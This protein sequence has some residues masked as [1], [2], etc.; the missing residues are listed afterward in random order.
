MTN[1]A[2]LHILVIILII[3]IS[4]VA[5]LKLTKDSTFAFLVGV[6]VG[7]VCLVSGV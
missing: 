2:L 5:T 4:Y 1:E 6:I 7:V 3:I